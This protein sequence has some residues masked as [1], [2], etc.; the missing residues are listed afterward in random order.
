MHP[1]R[2]AAPPRHGRPLNDADQPRPDELPLLDE[3]DRDVPVDAPTLWYEL[4]R[5]A[6][7]MLDPPAIARAYLRLQRADPPNGFA[8]VDRDEGRSVDLAGSHRHATYRVRFE[9]VPVDERTSRLRA[10]T[11]ARFHGRA[12]AI[13]RWLLL[14]SGGHALATKLLLRSIAQEADGH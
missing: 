4:S 13:Y 2:L 7:A 6:E 12:G 14:T 9:V 3:H 5:R 11:F 1:R 10:I 8:I